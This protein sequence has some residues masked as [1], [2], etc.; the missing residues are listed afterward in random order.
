MHTPL[1]DL[2]TYYN[3]TRLDYRLFWQARRSRA[4]H[5]GY[6]DD[7]ATTH[8]AALD[9]LNR[10]MADRAAI[11]PGERVLDAGCGLGHACFWLARH[12]GAQVT[13]VSLVPAQ[14]TSCRKAAG[15]MDNPTF[16]VADYC[17]LPFGHES[18][19]VVWACESICHTPMKHDFYREAFRML[20]PGGRLI[21]AEYLRTTRPS[22]REDLLA[23]WLHPWAIADLDTPAEHRQHALSSGFS[24]FDWLD[25]TPHM[26]PSLRNLHR[27]ASRFLPLG[28]FFARLRLLHPVRLGN[29]AGSIRQY[30]ALQEGAWR[31]G[32]LEAA[33]R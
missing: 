5:F 17:R 8:L 12:C 2:A 20:R 7:H 23:G 15:K 29:A 4:V 28:Q 14:I 26:R 30:E 31:Y 13:G 19:D 27:Q 6:Y 1:T 25:I 24:H 32:L 10:V 21:A 18:F 16:E 33:K 11:Q 22:A 9:N 3:K